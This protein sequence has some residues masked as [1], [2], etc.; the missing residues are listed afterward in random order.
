[1]K[2]S[3]RLVRDTPRITKEKPDILL[4]LIFKTLMAKDN[5]NKEKR[6]MMY[7]KSYLQNT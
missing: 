3:T 4:G 1:M 6:Q 2:T 5:I 7:Q